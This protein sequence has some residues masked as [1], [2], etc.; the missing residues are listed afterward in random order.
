MVAIRGMTVPGADASASS[1]LERGRDAFRRGAW[2]ECYAA[3]G[4]AAARE[5][6]E[7]GDLDLLAECAHYTGRTQHCADILHRLHAEHVAA[8]RAQAAALA[9]YRLHM[10]FALRGEEALAAGWLSRAARALGHL[11]DCVESGYI[12]LAESERAY[13]RAETSESLAAARRARQLGERHSDP[14]LVVVAGHLEGRALVRLHD[15]P[16]G[17]RLLDEAMAAAV[18]GELSPFYAVWV[19]CSSIIT[20]HARADIR[21]AAEWTAAF[22]RWS[23]RHPAARMFSGTCHL[24]RGEIKQLKGAWAEAEQENR[25]AVE[26]LKGLVAMDAAQASYHLAE[27]HRLRGEYEAAEAAFAEAGRLGTDVQP[28]LSLL[29]LGQGRPD[30][31]AAGLRRALSEPDRDVTARARLLP[32]FVEISLATGDR[33]QAGA[34]A[35]ELAAAATAIGTSALRALAAFSDGAVRLAHEDPAGGLARLRVADRL[36]QELEVPYERA[37]TLRLIGLGC[38]AAGDEDMATLALTAARRIF[39]E[40]GAGPDAGV[41]ERLLPGRGDDPAPAPPDGLTARE[42][43]VLR[44]VASGTTNRAVARQLHLSDRTVARHLSNIFAKTGLRSRAAATAYAFRNG[45]V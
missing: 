15:V 8:G 10:L 43:E 21:R 32:A 18:A 39:S 6:L 28:G 19:Y 9:A 25:Q 4:T 31:A 38:R 35:E 12:R 5:A 33:T 3:L 11:P 41:V 34:A 1:E 17:L 16:E 29:R 36:W 7:A 13:W 37:R 23:E 22:E 30:A 26:L 42:V 45:L 20:C 44:L 24:H 40:L 2:E 27:L 14:D